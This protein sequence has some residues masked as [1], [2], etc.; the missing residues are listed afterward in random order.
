MRNLSRAVSR[1]AAALHASWDDMW[2]TCPELLGS[3]DSVREH[4]DRDYDALLIEMAASLAPKDG[5]LDGEDV[6]PGFSLPLAERF[7]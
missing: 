1:C 2:G 5:A 6:L 3:T 4:F 7:A